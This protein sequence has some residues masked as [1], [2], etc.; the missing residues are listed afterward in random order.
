MLL[1][2]VEQNPIF[3]PNPL[4]R[5]E[6]LNVFNPAVIYHKALF[7][8]FYRAQGLDYVSHIGYAVSQDGITWNRLA[9]PVLSPASADDYRGVEDPRVTEIED[10]FYM[11]YTAYGVNRFFPM[12][13]R[14]TNLIIWERIG[15]LERAENKDHVLFPQKISGRFAAFHRRVPDIWIAYSHDLKQW[16][17][18]QRI[19]S[20][21][22]NN[23]WDCERVGAGGPPIAT[24]HGWLVIYHAFDQD[25]VYRL[26]VMLLDLEDP[27]KVINRPKAAIFEPHES[28]EIKGD[29]PNVVFSCANPV[30]DGTVYVYY[31][32]ADRV[33]GL[34][35]I[36]L[37]ALL[38]FAKHES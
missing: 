2:R 14:S 10:V 25:H 6:A 24:E 37:E 15:P 11:A 33:I 26:G 16:E 1:D 21:R 9:N 4:N 27:T 23:D 12:F 32:G 38:D 20:P 35:T 5:W 17:D 3:L 18:H 8:M 7:H 28:W 36:S 13:A 31:G 34:A 19:V 30:V 22:P 29:V